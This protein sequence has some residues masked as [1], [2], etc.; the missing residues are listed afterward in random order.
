VSWL[1]SLVERYRAAANPLR[2]ERRFEL[3]L[4]LLALLLILQLLYGVVRLALMSAPPPL[5]PP[6]DALQVVSAI[7]LDT[8]T[9]EQ[10]NEIRNR[11]VLWPG[12]R[13]VEAVTELAEE[14]NVKQQELEGIKLVG[15]FG[16]GDSAG[17]IARV[18]DKVR[19]IRLGEELA[20]WRLES[21][22]RNEAVITNGSRQEKVI[23]LPESVNSAGKANKRSER[24]Q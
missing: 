22:G 11:P 16:E 23:L 18:K 8:V 21:V 9:A 24:R 14:S 12:R 15:V 5:V 10:S 19:R 17:I 20:G 4:L 2:M 1:K 13:P 6:A 7:G 3:V